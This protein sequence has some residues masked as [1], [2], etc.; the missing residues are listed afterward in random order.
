MALRGIA[1]TSPGESGE[2]Q[3]ERLVLLTSKPVL[4]LLAVLLSVSAWKL[5]PWI[6]LDTC[7]AVCACVS[8][9]TLV[10]VCV[11]MC[12]CACVCVC[13][14]GSEARLRDSE[15][16]DTKSFLVSHS[17]E[18]LVIALGGQESSTR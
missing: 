11:Y 3:G 13:V 7:K 2:S 18:E 15:E 16:R 1:S 12:I 9:C 10:C 8:V 5:I 6:V 17:S 14:G 4:D